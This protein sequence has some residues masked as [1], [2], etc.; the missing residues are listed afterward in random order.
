[1]H[2]CMSMCACFV[3]VLARMCVSTFVYAPACACVSL[4]M[5]ALL[6]RKGAPRVAGKS[7][8][9]GLFWASGGYPVT[10]SVYWFSYRREANSGGCGRPSGLLLFSFTCLPSRRN[11]SSCKRYPALQA[12]ARIP[13]TQNSGG[14]SSKVGVLA[15]RC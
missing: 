1:M 6:G 13:R 11:A 14:L 5:R 10:H 4:Y 8:P 12:A 15:E 9:G 7:V 2:V 3:E